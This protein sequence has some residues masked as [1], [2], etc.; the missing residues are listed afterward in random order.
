[1]T[2]FPAD[3]VDGLCPGV[4]EMFR[5]LKPGHIRYPGGNFASGYHWRD[6]IGPRE[7]RP[8]RLNPAWVGLEP[9]E[10]GTDEF[11][12]F[13]ELTGMKAMLC[14]NFGSGTPE[15]AAEWVEYCNGST[16]TPMGR[17]RA[18]N[19]HPE[20]YN[21]IDWDIGN[22]VWGHWQIGHCPPNEYAKRFLEFRAA[23]RA[24][25][26]RIRL[27][28]CGHSPF[29]ELGR[30]WNSTI[31]K[32]AGEAIDIM[33]FHTYINPIAPHAVRDRVE[34]LHIILS[35]PHV[36]EQSIRDMA[37]RMRSHGIT[38]PKIAITEYNLRPGQFPSSRL[39]RM[40]HMLWYA[41]MLHVW[42]RTGDLVPICHITEL[43]SF[44]IYRRWLGSLSPR[45][46]VFK[47][48]ANQMGDRPLLARVRCPTY[49]I[50]KTVPPHRPL[51][52]VPIVDVIALAGRRESHEFITLAIVNKEFAR[53][54]DV[55]VVLHEFVPAPKGKLFTICDPNPSG[56]SQT[57]PR[58]TAQVG[59]I[60]VGPT[61][62]YKIPPCSVTLLRVEET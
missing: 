17:L 47:L 4:I 25:D 13:C 21:V 43:T 14:V 2:L 56:G 60:P 11:L 53:S 27:S 24:R 7:K 10:V 3:A 58:L 1:V 23:M 39:D 15:E 44:D 12:R 8:T 45:Y 48:Y 30:W 28:A 36:Y 32:V 31:Y 52:H 38:N 51:A 57:M 42:M 49:T 41:Q 40:A 35:H 46:E 26:P 9:N 29:H 20:P 16:D 19:G 22:E 37:D 18:Q 34:R 50:R 55:Q 61:F 59:T 62:A 6:G 33:T 5:E 54:V